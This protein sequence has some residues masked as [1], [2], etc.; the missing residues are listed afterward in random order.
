MKTFKD[1][2]SEE[3]ISLTVDEGFSPEQI[4]R[5]RQEFG[6]IDRVD[7]ES[8]TMRTVSYTHLPLPT[9]REV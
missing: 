5:L 4:K 6:K 1:F 9:N 7:P 3:S 8:P 2:L